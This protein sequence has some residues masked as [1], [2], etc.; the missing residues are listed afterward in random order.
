M[1]WCARDACCSTDPPGETGSQ[2][3]WLL[4]PDSKCDPETAY[5]KVECP[6]HR[7]P[8]RPVLIWPSWECSAK[9]DQ[10][11]DLHDAWGGGSKSQFPA[12]DIYNSSCSGE[13]KRRAYMSDKQKAQRRERDGKIWSHVSFILSKDEEQEVKPM[14]SPNNWVLKRM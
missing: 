2:C 5:A 10:L 9:H 1:G 7:H 4:L 6:R 8:C 3:L 13:T 14:A 11:S 12:P